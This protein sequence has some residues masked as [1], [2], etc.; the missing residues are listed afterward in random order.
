MFW[1]VFPWILAAVV[2]LIGSYAWVE[3]VSN[4]SVLTDPF[5]L[6]PVLGIWAWSVMWTHFVI[7]EIRR[8]KP[9]L[10]KNIQYKK[11]SFVFVLFCILLHPGLLI[12][13]QYEAG[14]GLSLANAYVGAARMWAVQ[15][16]VIAFFIFLSFEFFDRMR[17]NPKVEKKWWIVNI[18]QSVAM[19]LIFIHSLT[20]GTHLQQGWFSIYWILLGIILAG[21][22]IHTH[23]TDW[24]YFRKKSP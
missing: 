6:F 7:D 11:T 8:F 9:K 5:V 13:A 21:C 12:Y 2:I 19:I 17:E 22:I 16:A 24:N 14:L 20:L 3:R 1:K 23:I 18:S 4:Y 10:P 15:I